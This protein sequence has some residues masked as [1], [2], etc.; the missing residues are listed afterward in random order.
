[1]MPTVS[2]PRPERGAVAP[3]PRPKMLNATPPRMEEPAA[4]ATSDGAP[5]AEQ[6]RRD[7]LE[8]VSA[9]TGYP[10]DALDEN[11][12]LESGLGIDSIKTVEIFSKLK[13]YH[14]YFRAEGEG[15]EELLAEFTKM[16]TLRDIVNSYDRRRQA[17]R[18]QDGMAATDRPAAHGVEGA[19]KRYEV[20]PVDSPLQVN[21]SKKNYLTGSS[22]W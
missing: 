12:P 21:G 5:S 13:P 20:V 3:P 10:I 16:K 14:I 8:V 7:L 18:A 11:L 9:R 6:F 4:P 22:S 15:E 1:M 19:V 17:H 2:A